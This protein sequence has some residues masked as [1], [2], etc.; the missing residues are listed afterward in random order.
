[1]RGLLRELIRPRKGAFPSIFGLP[2]TGPLHRQSVRSRMTITLVQQQ[3]ASSIDHL[4]N[5]PASQ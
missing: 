1:M 4:G 2:H 3:A 5:L